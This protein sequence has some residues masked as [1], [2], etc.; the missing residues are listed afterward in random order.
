[1]KG[2][3]AATLYGTEAANGVIQIFTKRGSAT[4]TRYDLHVETGISNYPD[5]A[6]APHAG[7]ARRQSQ[8]DSLTAFWKLST[9]LAPYQ[10][11]SVPLVPQIIETGHN[12]TYSLS[13]SGG[14]AQ[15]NYFVNG[16]YQRENGPFGGR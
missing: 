15:V 2:A 4:A 14:A 6:Y 7:F 12:S 5:D 13:A 3:A 11:F 10:V 9:P 8:A 16:R 1:M